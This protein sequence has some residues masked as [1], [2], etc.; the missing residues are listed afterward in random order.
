MTLHR[1]YNVQ[2][3]QSHVR[4]TKR[5][6]R[7]K[8]RELTIDPD[9][10]ANFST[11]KLN[12]EAAGFYG[13]YPEIIKN[14]GQRTK[15]WIVALFNDILMSG[16]IRK[17]FKRA[18]VIT[19][20]KPRKDGSDLSHLLPISLVSIVFTILER[21]IL[22]RIQLLIDAVVPVSQAGSKSRAIDEESFTSET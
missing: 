3:D 6:L 8:R 12:T 22:Q 5:A 10:S 16:K 17:L 18:K 21:N 11:E 19:I 9:L 1:D 15:E 2:M 14:S 20:L 13:V 4:S 7:Q